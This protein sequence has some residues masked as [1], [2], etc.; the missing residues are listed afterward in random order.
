M[1]SGASEAEFVALAS[2]AE[3]GFGKQY[4]LWIQSQHFGRPQALQEH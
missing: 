2:H 4:V 3:L 1:V